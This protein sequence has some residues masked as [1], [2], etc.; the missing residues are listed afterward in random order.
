VKPEEVEFRIELAV[1]DGRERIVPHGELDVATQ[2]EL[3][4]ELERA[5]TGGAFTLDLSELSFI[6]TSGLRLV[7][8]TAEAARGGAFGFDVV[9]GRPA[10]QRLFEVAGVADLVPFRGG[11]GS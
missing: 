9:P 2:A 3:R 7:L 6:D 11:A 8:E 5:A 1:D 10:I 4:A